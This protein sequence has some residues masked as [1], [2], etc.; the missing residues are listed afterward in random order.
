MSGPVSYLMGS[1][2][3]HL[4]TWLTAN[5]ISKVAWENRPLDPAAVDGT[6]AW[7]RV[8]FFPK[9]TVQASVGDNGL[10]EVGGIMLVNLFYP[11]G[12]NAGTPNSLADSLVSHFKRGTLTGAVSGYSAKIWNAWRDAALQE[13]AWFNVPV[14]VRYYQQVENV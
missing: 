11:K 14:R 5:S 8:S 4:Q 7:A 9:E 13:P 1:M 3:Q 12:K 6:E 10:N 2:A